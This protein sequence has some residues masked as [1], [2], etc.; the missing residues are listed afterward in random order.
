MDDQLSVD[1]TPTGVAV[2][3]IDPANDTNAIALYNEALGLQRYAESRVIQSVEDI[4]HATD[5]LGL[6]GKLKKAIEQKRKEYVDPI[7]AHLKAI[8]DAFKTIVVPLDQADSLTRG[9]ILAFKREE[10]RKAAEIAEINRL[11]IEA[12]RR[13]AMLNEGELSELTRILPEVAPVPAMVRTDMST[14]G[15]A[16]IWKWEI[17]DIAKVPDEY[18]L[19]DAS[20]IGKVVRAGLRDIPGI[21]IYSED[22]LRVTSK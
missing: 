1:P 7:N 3:R 5:D 12:A 4:A 8:N 20:K 17:V 16:K 18:K 13:E 15:T 2:I 21:R 22:S 11:R 10:A 19:V 9:K 6:V 14:M